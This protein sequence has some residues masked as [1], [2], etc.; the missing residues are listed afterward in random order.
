MAVCTKKDICIIVETLTLSALA[1]V[2]TVSS[3]GDKYTTNNKC[4]LSYLDQ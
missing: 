4:P 1:Q 3:L 2:W